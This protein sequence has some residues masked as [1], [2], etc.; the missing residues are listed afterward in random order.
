M[1][2]KTVKEILGEFVDKELD[3]EKE[4]QVKEHF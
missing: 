4:S 3:E 2:C 1:D